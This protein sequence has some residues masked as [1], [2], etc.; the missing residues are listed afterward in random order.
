MYIREKIIDEI[1]TLPKEE[2]K[3]IKQ[4]LKLTKKPNLS[5]K[6][7]LEKYNKQ[8]AIYEKLKT[9]VQ[10]DL[11]RKQ[12]RIS[13]LIEENKNLENQRKNTKKKSA[14][15][16]KNVILRIKQDE[17]EDLSADLENV[18]ITDTLLH[19]YLHSR[20]K[21]LEKEIKDIEEKDI[22]DLEDEYEEIV[23]KWK[24][25]KKRRNRKNTK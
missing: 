9:K 17:L 25:K 7:D 5:K 6:E 16:V 8:K 21:K 4:F 2:Q 20:I 12:N 13:Q 10:S 19:S 1:P 3:E 18:S 15:N 14:L 24:A 22:T 11:K 23:R